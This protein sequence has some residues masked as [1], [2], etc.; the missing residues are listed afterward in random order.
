[1][2]T[3]KTTSLTTMKAAATL[4][5]ALTTAACFSASAAVE[6]TSLLSP[7]PVSPAAG[8]WYKSDM[9]AGGT[10]SLV[11]LTG[12]GGDL[13]NNVPLPTGALKLTTGFSNDDKAEVATF[14][15]FGDATTVLNA[16]TL[17]YSYY[18]QTVG[19][20]NIYAA[21]ALKLAILGPNHDQD[22][23]DNYGQLVYEPYWN[24]PGGGAPPAPADA[25]QTVSI[26]ASTGD[27]DNIN[28]GGWWWTGGFELPSGSGGPPLQSLDEW[29]ADFQSADGAD[30]AGARVVGIS[31]GVGTYNQGQVGYVDELIIGGTLANETYNFQVPE[32]GSLALL[33]FGG[34]IAVRRRRSS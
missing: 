32:P 4:A 26:D 1:M 21:P 20:G 7:V 27:D 22:T 34:L 33:G 25:W 10:A 30:F 9:R 8:A 16:I 18:K 5:A 31:F 23:N 6:V 24:Q 15:D 13:E 3:N 19:G 28:S 12:L 2:K 11:D 29:I 14:D 17:Q